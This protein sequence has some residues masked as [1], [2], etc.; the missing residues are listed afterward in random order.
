MNRVLTEKAIEKHSIHHISV[1]IHKQK[2][3]P[4]GGGDEPVFSSHATER[5]KNA[6]I[7]ACLRNGIISKFYNLLT[8]ENS[9]NK[10]ETKIWKLKS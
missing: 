6:R 10:A 2:R 1:K 5:L 7:K 8:S 3:V 4:G 9:Q